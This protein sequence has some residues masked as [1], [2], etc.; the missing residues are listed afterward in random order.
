MTVPETQPA[1]AAT[2]TSLT[3]NQMAEWRREQGRHVVEHE[4]RWW[5]ASRAGFYRPIHLLARLR[6]DEAERPTAACWGFHATL[7]DEDAERANAILPTHRVT[8]LDAFDESHLSSNRRYQ[9]RKARRLVELLHLTGPTLLREQGH[10]VV[11]SAVERTGFGDAKSSEN[12]VRDVEISLRPNRRFVL[13]GVSDGTL[14]GYVE[15]YAVGSVAYLE[16]LLIATEALTT[17]VSSALQFEFAQAAR[18][19]AGIR[20]LVHGIR[21]PDDEKLTMYKERLGFPVQPVPAK[22]SM[23]PGAA[24]IIRWRAPAS[25]YRLTGILA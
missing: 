22:V 20:E 4:G 23:L 14:A 7:R 11:R 6:A 8:D 21:A 2:L 10:E 12:Y 25:F 18:R 24:R 3:E 17:N 19:A 9:L 5:W 16:D 15:G 13:A 1:E